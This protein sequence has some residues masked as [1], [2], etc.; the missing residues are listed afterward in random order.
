MWTKD[1]RCFDVIEKAWKREFVG[2]DGLKLC[3]KQVHIASALRKWNKEVFGHYQSKFFEISRKIEEIKCKD[4]SEVNCIKEVNLQ[5]ELNCWLSRNESMWRRKSRETWLKNGDR[6]TRYFHTSA[7][8][9]RRH[10]SIDAIRGVDGTSLVNFLDI[11]EFVVENFTQL[12]SEEDT[13]FPMNLDN[14]ISPILSEF[15]NE[16]LCRMPTP[17]EI[18]ENIDDGKQRNDLGDVVKK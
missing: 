10:N 9:R 4:P 18:K 1:P 17:I 14:L 13:C 6:N 8:V 12:F 16:L 5:A 15:D 11:R 2:N 7:V 3:R